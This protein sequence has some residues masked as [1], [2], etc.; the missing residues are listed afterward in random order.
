MF[1]CSVF[2]PITCT[3]ENKIIERQ[4]SQGSCQVAADIANET[5]FRKYNCHR[6]VAEFGQKAKIPHF[7]PNF[8]NQIDVGG[9]FYRDTTCSDLTMAKDGN[10]C[11]FGVRTNLPNQKYDWKQP[12][13]CVWVLEQEKM[14]CVVSD[15][16]PWSKCH[17]DEKNCGQGEQRRNK[18]IL[19]PSK[20][21]GKMCP[22]ESSSEMK[23]TRACDLPKK[24]PISCHP[25]G[26]STCER[27]RLDSAGTCEPIDGWS[28]LFLSHL[29]TNVYGQTNYGKREL[30][31]PWNVANVGKSL[32]LFYPTRSVNDRCFIITSGGVHDHSQTG[33]SKIHFLA[34]DGIGFTPLKKAACADLNN[35]G[36]ACAQTTCC[37]YV[38]KPPGTW[39]MKNDSWVEVDNTLDIDPTFTGAKPKIYQSNTALLVDGAFDYL[40]EQRDGTYERESVVHANLN[41]QGR[42][43]DAINTENTS[44][45]EGPSSSC[46]SQIVAMGSKAKIV[47]L[48]IRSSCKD[49]TSGMACESVWK[50]KDF[51]YPCCV[52]DTS[53][54]KKATVNDKSVQKTIGIGHTFDS[55]WKSTIG[56]C[57][58]DHCAVN[59]AGYMV[60][61]H[62]TNNEKGNGGC[63]LQRG[64]L[65]PHGAGFCDYELCDRNGD[66]CNGFAPT[67]EQQNTMKAS[68]PKSGPRKKENYWSLVTDWKVAYD[69][70]NCVASE[71]HHCQTEDEFKNTFYDHHPRKYLDPHTSKIWVEQKLSNSGDAGESVYILQTEMDKILASPGQC[72]NAGLQQSGSSSKYDQEWCESDLANRGRHS[73]VF[74]RLA[75]NSRTSQVTLKDSGE[76]PRAPK[77]SDF[78]GPTCE[79]AMQRV[80]DENGKFPYQH[81]KYTWNQKPACCTWTPTPK[82]S[83]LLQL[84]N[85]ENPKQVCT[86]KKG[87]QLHRGTVL[88]HV[89]KFKEVD[90]N[91][92]WQKVQNGTTGKIMY[93]RESDER[94]RLATRGQCRP[95]A[96]VETS[97]EFSRSQCADMTEYFARQNEFS[98]ST[99]PTCSDLEDGPTCEAVGLVQVPDSGNYHSTLPGCCVWE[100]HTDDW[101]VSTTTT[102]TTTAPPHLE[103]DRTFGNCVSI[104]TRKT[105]TSRLRGD[106]GNFDRQCQEIIRGEASKLEK[107]WNFNA[108]PKDPSKRIVL[109]NPPSCGDMIDHRSGSWDPST[110]TRGKPTKCHDG[111]SQCCKWGSTTKRPK[112]E[113][114]KYKNKCLPRPKS[115]TTWQNS[116]CG[117]WFWNPS[118]E[119]HDICAHLTL[120]DCEKQM[121]STF[122]DVIYLDQRYNNNESWRTFFSNATGQKSVYDHSKTNKW[123]F[124]I[125]GQ[126]RSMVS[127]CAIGYGKYLFVP[128]RS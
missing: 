25:A 85:K 123:G 97:Y 48:S 4:T 15:F 74:D 78:V 79:Q 107:T 60:E 117:K 12:S 104:S 31:C 59:N 127:C 109:S 21:G 99:P 52:W 30:E 98:S 19:I 32:G 110:H 11:E 105:A 50:N 57:G 61:C 20:F 96:N 100:P 101:T 116:K 125:V 51:K 17:S 119:R 5:E 73:G 89:E 69:E 126:N 91:A 34:P 29:K 71:N 44:M 42:C 7:K 43:Q 22:K 111:L 16:G 76:Q 66:E 80:V 64:D 121:Q 82:K 92:L 62:S 6:S 27:K 35:Q 63:T 93:V 24:C 106:N 94:I 56:S 87:E 77:C 122:S 108:S 88:A 53:E 95:A 45:A 72:I 81:N 18:N 8:N 115:A 13:C 120:L 28:S 9:G 128:A 102:T 103:E 23:E 113:A 36:H 75:G 124:N 67:V 49:L 10:L 55:R 14:D 26:S 41:K 39:K 33:C 46:A 2:F 90:S 47:G 58:F 68:K 114:F 3:K 83:L 38:A 118:G 70:F 112:K 40:V 37:K 84:F 54:D 86:H 65:D 1:F